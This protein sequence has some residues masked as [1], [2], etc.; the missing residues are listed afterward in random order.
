MVHFSMQPHTRH[1]GCCSRPYDKSTIARPARQSPPATHKCTCAR[2]IKAVQCTRTSASLLVF[3]TRFLS[4][5]GHGWSAMRSSA[6]PRHPPFP[7]APHRPGTRPPHL[8]PFPSSPSTIADCGLPSPVP[9]PSVPLLP[10]V[11]SHI[12]FSF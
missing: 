9:F 5:R 2:C 3:T 11:T 10:L 4:F 7:R 6:S 8:N 1:G 12:S